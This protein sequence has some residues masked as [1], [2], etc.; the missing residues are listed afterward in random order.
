MAG[1]FAYGFPDLQVV[2]QFT[3]VSGEAE[4]GDVVDAVLIKG[5]L[6]VPD[7]LGQLDLLDERF[8]GI[9]AVCR[10]IAKGAGAG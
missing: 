9:V 10:D 6:D 3:R 2:D 8:V 1:A 5:N 4:L 7:E